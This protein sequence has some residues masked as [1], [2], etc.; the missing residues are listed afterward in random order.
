MV[1]DV[2]MTVIT[3]DGAGTICTLNDRDLLTEGLNFNR[4]KISRALSEGTQKIDGN[5]RQYRVMV[6]ENP[7]AQIKAD[8]KRPHVQE[9]A[10]FKT[11]NGWRFVKDLKNGDLVKTL[12]FKC[13]SC[14]KPV[15]NARPLI[16]VCSYNCYL[17]AVTA[18]IMVFR[19]LNI[20]TLPFFVEEGWSYVIGNPRKIGIP[21]GMQI[22]NVDHI[23][24]ANS[25]YI[26]NILMS[27]PKLLGS[28]YNLKE[29]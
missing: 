29:G 24:G 21:A 26:C 10:M 28:G 9:S 6:L 3:Q 13:V 7:N 23:E 20:D 14:Q 25:L 5:L 8:H 18:N 22:A 2:L 4:V 16:S 17:A 1:T 27:N 11:P 12:K 15:F 19:A